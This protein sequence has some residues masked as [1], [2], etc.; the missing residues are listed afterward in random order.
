MRRA[1]EYAD[2]LDKMIIDHAEDMTMCRQ[3]FMNEGTNSYCMGV[4]GRPAAG[5]D[6]AVARDIILSELTDVYKR[7]G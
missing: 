2:M 4:T 6:I 1:M 7:Q 5:E 3:G